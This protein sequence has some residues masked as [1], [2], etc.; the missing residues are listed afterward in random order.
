MA[1]VPAGRWADTITGAAMRRITATTLAISAGVFVIGLVG[2]FVVF[3]GFAVSRDEAMARFDETIIAH[4]RLIWSV[5]VHWRPYADALEPLFR[6]PVRDNAGWVSSYL[7][8]NAALRAAFGAIA[9]PMLTGPTL[10]ALSIVALMGI[11]RKLWPGRPDAVVVAMLMLASSSQLLMMS[12]TAYAMTAHLA[13]NLLWLWLFLR[14]DRSSHVGAVLVGALATGLHQLVFHPL[15]VMPFVLSLW[16]TR[17]FRLAAWYTASYAFIVLFWIAYW[18]MILH[19]NGMQGASTVE[20]GAFVGKVWDLIRVFDIGNIQ[21]MTG[22]LVRFTTW[23]NPI[24][25]PLILVAFVNV[26]TM[27]RPIVLAAWGILATFVLVFAVL[28]F[29]GHGWGYRYVHG[30]L[31]SFAL[32]VGHGWVALTSKVSEQTRR[33]IATQV[34][35]ASIFS[36]AVLLPARAYQTQAFV[37]PFAKAEDLIQHADSAFVFVDSD[38]IPYATDL[39]RNDPQLKN[40]PLV[41]DLWSLTDAQVR[42]LCATDDVSVFDQTDDIA[43]DFPFRS[44]RFL[45]PS[46]PLRATMTQMHCGRPIRRNDAR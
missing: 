16:L 12:M 18:Q 8:I 1:I 39:V 33:T 43:S 3:H 22:N 38:V 32:L 19:A 5:P 7:P 2:T 17:R 4:G 20:P 24:L 40:H 29:Q 44:Q 10:A 6:L 11:G 30:L 25:I 21:I 27:P 31:G 34:L 41:F 28:P 14:E 35:T 13:L 37:A 15:F 23:Q 46:A 36:F 9:S 42:A 45:G 26:K